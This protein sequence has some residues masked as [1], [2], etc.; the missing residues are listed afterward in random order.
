[1]TTTIR[2][3][4]EDDSVKSWD[5][6]YVEDT[7]QGADPNATN[8]FNHRSDWKYEPP[9]Q[10]EEIL[11]PTA[12]EIEAIRAAAQA[13]GFA[14]GHKEGLEKGIE[15]GR[16]QGKQ[17]G[18][19]QGIEQGTEQGLA[20]GEEQAK[21]QIEIWTELTNKLQHPV[22]IVDQELEKELVLLAVSLAKA[23][24]RCE[25]KSNTDIVFQALSEG[26]KALP[27]NEKQYQIHLHPEDIS[28]I[29]DHFSEQD[30]EKH[31][32]HFVESLSLSRGG[33]DIVTDT[34]AV[35]VS[36]ERRVRD[37]LDKF[38]LEQGLGHVNLD[39]DQ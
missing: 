5:L 38:M 6:P 16:I 21:E 1:V 32:W 15:E 39:Q 7:Y 27:I 17:E 19:D 34:N 11:P 2:T 35:D 20:S 33:C 24:I 10:E 14:Q 28:L 26:L 36:V 31:G 18:L 3:D 23:V 25:V 29:K 12:A 37:V 8:A 4:E 13:D 30:I 9:E 22:S